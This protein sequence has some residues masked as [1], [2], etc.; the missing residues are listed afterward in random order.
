LST[1]PQLFEFGYHL[2]SWD[3]GGEPV[4]EGLAF[5]AAS[6]FKWFEALVG[7][8][9]SFDHARRFMTLPAGLP[10]ATRDFEMLA[11]LGLFSRAQTEHGIRVASLYA[12]PVI[13]D[14]TAWPI[15]RDLII[16]I[17]RFLQ[18]C[19]SNI[20]VVGGGPPELSTPHSPED[21]QLVASRL[22]DIGARAQELG[23]R[24]VYHPHLDCFIE[25][26]DQLDRL[27]DII[28]TTLVGLCID[29][30]HLQIKATDP[31]QVLRTYANEVDYIHFKDCQGDVESL[32]GAD[33]YRSFCELGTGVVDFPGMTEVML[34]RG[35][36]GIVIIELDRSTKGAQ[37]S[38]CESIAYVTDTLGLSLSA[39]QAAV[40]V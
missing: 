26:G 18:G 7:D 31:V 16:A 15:E 4:D 1:P 37:T 14:D 21:Y 3:L 38:C 23:L 11:R 40:P 30:A 9:L 34:K 8:S 22:E 20:L 27:M 32:R 17:A 39:D 35:Y 25:T 24:A 6:G 5:L 29:P 2:N 36:D 13:V 12:N 33:R 28:D 19:G 10:P